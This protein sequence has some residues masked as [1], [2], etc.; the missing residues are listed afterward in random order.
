MKIKRNVN[1]QEMEFEL[2]FE[3]QRKVF[4]D[5]RTECDKEDI[6]D[7]LDDEDLSVTDEQ[8]SLI[9]DKYRDYL[10]EDDTWRYCAENAIDYVLNNK[11]G[12]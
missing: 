6:Q 12:K 4:Y 7:I 11:E 5:Y 10:S 1:G 3:E 2:T 9:V 8:M